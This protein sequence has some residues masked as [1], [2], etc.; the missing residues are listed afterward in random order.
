MTKDT[1]NT[2][3]KCVE[4]LMVQLDSSGASLAAKQEGL[5]E[6]ITSSIS[7]TQPDALL[8][9]SGGESSTQLSEESEPSPSGGLEAGIKAAF[10]SLTD[11]QI[12]DWLQVL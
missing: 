10:P 3:E 9:P 4:E 7:Q 11:E 12:E 2:L 1:N 5:A 6:L 8:P